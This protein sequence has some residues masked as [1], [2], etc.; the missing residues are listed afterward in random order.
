[1]FDPELVYDIADG[2]TEQMWIDTDGSPY[3]YYTGPDY[4]F[5]HCCNY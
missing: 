3:V 4:R 5:E 1:M 2:G